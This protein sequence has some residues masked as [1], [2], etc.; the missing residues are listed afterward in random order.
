MLGV[1]PGQVLMAAG[2]RVL[3]PGAVVRSLLH[4]MLLLG[5]MVDRRLCM[6][7]GSVPVLLGAGL[8]GFSMPG[9][10]GYLSFVPGRM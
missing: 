8:V 4:V 9:V 10:P 5:L 7:M 6:P 1:L 2:D 3:A